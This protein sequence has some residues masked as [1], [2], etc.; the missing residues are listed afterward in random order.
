MQVEYRIIIS[1]W[2]RRRIQTVKLICKCLW[3]LAAAAGRCSL[4]GSW[5]FLWQTVTACQSSNDFDLGRA[6]HAPA[7]LKGLGPPLRGGKTPNLAG[8]LTIWRLDRSKIDEG[9]WVAVDFSIGKI[10]V[11]LRLDGSKMKV[12]YNDGDDALVSGKI[13]VRWRL[14]KSKIEVRWR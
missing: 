9:R 3:I 14:D 2:K 4:A 12:E 5:Q 7:L 6:V 13:E 8:R 1:S 10:E 11:R